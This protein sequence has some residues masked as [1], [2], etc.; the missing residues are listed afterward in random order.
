MLE[1][2]TQGPEEQPPEL[3]DRVAESRRN[4]SNDVSCINAPVALPPLKKRHGGSR[5]RSC[6]IGCDEVAVASEISS[7]EIEVRGFLSLYSS[8]ALKQRQKP[9]TFKFSLYSNILPTRTS[10]RG[11]EI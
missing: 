5:G 10:V 4:F 6:S 11:T 9:A 2:D 1:G 3:G 8:L 7:F